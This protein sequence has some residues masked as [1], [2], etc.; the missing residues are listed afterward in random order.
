[1]PMDPETFRTK[2]WSERLEIFNGISAEE[3]AV[4][5]RA[6][7]GWWLAS[8][9]SELSDAQAAIL[10]ENIAFVTADIYADAPRGELLARLNELEKR[11]AELLSRDQMREA[12][13]MHW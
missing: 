6:N 3:K 9:R 10:E 7:I 13:T 12:L 2:S 1:M 4:L 11:T 8:H 5:V